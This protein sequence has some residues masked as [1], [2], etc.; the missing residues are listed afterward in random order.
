MKSYDQQDETIES[1]KLTAK[2]YRL[3]AENARGLLRQAEHQVK[4]FQ[5]R[6]EQIQKILCR[7]CYCGINAE[8]SPLYQDGLQ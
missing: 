5:E 1:L 8:N 2:S 4:N 3:E 6:M 7:D